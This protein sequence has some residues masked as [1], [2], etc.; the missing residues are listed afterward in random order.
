MRAACRSRCRRRRTRWQRCLFQNTRMNRVE[1]EPL[2]LKDLNGG[3]YDPQRR[4]RAESH[5]LGRSRAQDSSARRWRTT[6]ISAISGVPTSSSAS[7]GA[8]GSGAPARFDVRAEFFNVVQPHSMNN[9]DAVNPLQTQQRNAQGVP[10]SGFGR[11]NTGTVFGPPRSGQIVTRF[12]LVGIGIRDGTVP[13]VVEREACSTSG[14]EPR[15][16]EKRTHEAERLSECG[17]VDGRGHHAGGRRERRHC[18]GAAGAC[19]RPGCHASHAEARLPIRTAKVEILFKAPGLSGNGMQCTAEGIWTIDNA[20]SRGDTPGRCK[21]YLSSYEGKMLRELSPE[22]DR[23]ERHR[24][25][26]GQ[27]AIWI[28]STYSREIIRADAKTGETMEKHFTP[29]AGVIYRRTTDIPA[30][31]DTYGQKVACCSGDAGARRRPLPA[32]A[33]WWR[34]TWPWRG[35]PEQRSGHGGRSRCRTRRRDCRQSRSPRAR[36]RRARTCRRRTASCG[37]PCR[38]AG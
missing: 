37:S 29:G 30:R 18:R 21:V 10:T 22:G 4:F 3:D 6:M 15:C 38:R 14:S 33:G 8:S 5:S 1:G 32:A 7:A 23:A 26:R 13:R 35:R 24:R 16:Y 9:P 19:R 25:R 17:G 2:Y 34:R 27:R 20:G 11:I 31:P 28:G 12:Q 36:N